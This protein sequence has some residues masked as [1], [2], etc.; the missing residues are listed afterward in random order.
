MYQIVNYRDFLKAIVS[1]LSSLLLVSCNAYP[2]SQAYNS[3]IHQSDPNATPKTAALLQNLGQLKSRH[4][5]FGH[6][7]SLAYGVEWWDEPGRSDV[8][9]VTGDYP[10]LYGWDLGHLELGHAENLDGV[11]FESMKKWILQGYDQ[12]AVITMSW[13]MTHPGTGGS[14]WQTDVG[15]RD[16]LPGGKHHQALVDTLDRFSGFVRSLVPDGETGSRPIPIIFRPW[17]EH[18]GDWFWWGKKS[19]QEDT[20]IKLWRFTVDY[21]RQEKNLHNLLYAFSPDRSRIDIV[22]FDKSYLYGYPG[23]KYVDIL[24]LD[25]YWDLGHEANA[26]ISD[27]QLED[28]IESLTRLSRLAFKKDKLAALT[29]SGQDTLFEPD[30][31]TNRFLNGIMANC[32]TQDIAYAMVWRNAN[33]EREERRHFYVP[34]NGQKSADSFQRFYEHKASLFLS[35]LP[36]MYD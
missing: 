25:N 19:T 28:F 5:I 29:E 10:A 24:G 35:D 8:L 16:L 22:N 34:Y 1:V 36:N 15:A 12:G 27:K 18:N 23:D 17:H 31:W 3:R 21:L 2:E 7:D 4:F 14:S 9:E 6:Q 13:H 30:F 11:S 32:W 20:Y 26:K 33:F